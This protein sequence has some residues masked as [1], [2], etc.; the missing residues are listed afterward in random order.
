MTKVKARAISRVNF[1]G[2][3]KENRGKERKSNVRV[4]RR[5]LLGS[6]FLV[7]IEGNPS[8]LSLSL[9]LSLSLCLYVFTYIFIKR[10]TQLIIG[11][12]TRHCLLQYIL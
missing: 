11:R 9:F 5:V 2:V 10:K 3:E 8:S 4:C 1:S 12:S 6:W 7:Q